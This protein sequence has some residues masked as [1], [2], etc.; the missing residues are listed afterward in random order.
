MR[1]KKIVGYDIP[2]FEDFICS[3]CYRG[4]SA[5]HKQDLGTIR[6]VTA[7]EAWGWSCIDCEEEC[8][9]HDHD[10]PEFSGGLWMAELFGEFDR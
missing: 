3:G 7:S 6:A 4:R 9:R 10:V 8:G 2:Q 1:E 5:E